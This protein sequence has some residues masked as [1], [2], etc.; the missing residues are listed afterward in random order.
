MSGNQVRLQAIEQI[1]NRAPK[2]VAQTKPLSQIW[3][4]DVFNLAKMEDA[5]SKKSV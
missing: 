1:T 5:L 3:A 4:T 2:E